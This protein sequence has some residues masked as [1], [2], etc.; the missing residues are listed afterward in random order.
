M[1]IVFTK[2]SWNKW[3]YWFSIFAP[4]S[5][6]PIYG[7]SLYD[8]FKKFFGDVY[9]FVSNKNLRDVW[10]KRYNINII[11]KITG[12]TILVNESIYI[13]PIKYVDLIRKF[14][15]SCNESK[16]MVKLHDTP[17][18]IYSSDGFSSDELSNFNSIYKEVEIKT[19]DIKISRY[20]WNLLRHYIENP[21]PS[22]DTLFKE[23]LEYEEIFPGVYSRRADF[24]ID[25]RYTILDSSSGPIIFDGDIEL[26]GFNYIKGPVYL[27]DGTKVNGA[28][29]YNSVIGP[30][31]RIGGEVSDSIILGYSNAA[32]FSYVGHSLIGYWVN[33]GAGSV[34]SDLK[35]TY[36]E[37][38]VKINDLEFH[39]GLIK[40]GSIVGD[41]VKVS[42]NTSIY[43]GKVI[44]LSSHVSGKVDKS[45]PPF[46]LYDGWTR[47]SSKMDVYKAIEFMKRMYIRRNVKFIDEEEKLFFD[48]FKKLSS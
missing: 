25:D 3:W 17:I 36:G 16:C 23:Y 19:M 35:N 46:T 37:V 31:C 22:I 9:L 48:L 33:I 29:V 32:H 1:K 27:G 18:I 38:R 42:I 43:G 47:D 21:I 30:V 28:K 34:F 6:W 14:L 13:D 11:D 39:T 44:G 24:H 5:L 26:N 20:P 8:V 40:F 2:F 7:I 41:Y 10:S 15:E 45:I 12:E 4:Q